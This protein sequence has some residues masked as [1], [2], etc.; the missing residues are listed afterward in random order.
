RVFG[1]EVG[2]AHHAVEKA[3]FAIQTHADVDEGNSSRDQHVENSGARSAF[4]NTHEGECHAVQMM[5]RAVV[6]M[7][8]LDA[9]SVAKIFVAAIVDVGLATAKFSRVE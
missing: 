3:M 4:V 2:C 5:G 9:K 1:A 7:S 8:S 6:D